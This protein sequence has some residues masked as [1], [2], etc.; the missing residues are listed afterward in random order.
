MVWGGNDRDGKS[1]ELTGG[2]EALGGGEEMGVFDVKG[3]KDI[4]LLDDRGKDMGMLDVSGKE[5]GVFDDRGG[6]EAGAFD[7]GEGEEAGLFDDGEGEE[8]GVVDKKDRG[9]G[10]LDKR[11]AVEVTDDD[12]EEV[13]V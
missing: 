7:D 1:V 3:G 2:D 9:M 10:M 13:G 12:A 6:E 4:G 11:G 5:I 8:E